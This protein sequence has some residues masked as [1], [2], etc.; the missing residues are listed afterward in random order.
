MEKE[1]KTT[2][3]RL[4]FTNNEGENVTE[5]IKDGRTVP[6]INYDN[7]LEHAKQTRSYV[8]DLYCCKV[9]GGKRTKN[10]FYGWA[11]PK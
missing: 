5:R 1:E 4:I 6:F 9:K 8:Y 10:A 11:V 2:E 3:D 7:A